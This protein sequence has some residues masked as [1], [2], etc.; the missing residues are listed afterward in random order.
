MSSLII[1]SEFQGVQSLA[2]LAVEGNRF[3]V[4]FMSLFMMGEID[5]CID[6]LVKSGRLPEAAIMARSYAP[7]YAEIAIYVWNV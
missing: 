3:N 4:A 2:R 5:Q 7:R 1:A 6:V